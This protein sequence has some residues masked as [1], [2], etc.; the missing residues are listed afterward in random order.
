[1]TATAKQRSTGSAGQAKRGADAR[2]WSW[3]EAARPPVLLVHGDADEVLPVAALPRA[4]AGLRAAGVAVEAHVRPGLGHGID[5]E[6]LALASAFL[7][8]AIE[9]E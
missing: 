2:D 5:A 1:M 8:R 7:A 9:A 4:A 3:A 6:G